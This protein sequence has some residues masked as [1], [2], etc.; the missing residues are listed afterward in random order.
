MKLLE[1]EVQEDN[2]QE[3][4]TIPKKIREMAAEEGISTE[5]KQKV[6][7]RLTNVNTGEEYLNR[8]AITGTHEIYVPVE[9][10]KMLEGSGNIRIRI[11]G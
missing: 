11:F 7:A 9:I 6:V 8:L 4:I 5:N 2:Y 1:W 10:Q 3:Q